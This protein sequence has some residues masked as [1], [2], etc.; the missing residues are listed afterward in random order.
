MKL[1]LSGKL[2][3]KLQSKLLLSTV[4][5]VAGL[6]IFGSEVFAVGATPKFFICPQ[7]MTR[8]A[9]LVTT[10]HEINLCGKE[11]K[12]PTV[13][14]KRLRGQKDFTTVRIITNKHP[15]HTARGSDG[16]VYTIDYKKLVLTIQPKKGKLLTEKII[17]SD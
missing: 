17:A 16:T 2:Q 5:T 8:A 14:A 4:F 12:E 15:L 1:N 7:G 11:G 9:T 13:L 10:K 6:S 3:L